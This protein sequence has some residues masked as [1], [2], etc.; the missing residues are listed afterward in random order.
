MKFFFK[1]GE[2]DTP[3]SKILKMRFSFLIGGVSY[4]RPPCN[5]LV[6]EISHAYHALIDVENPE[7]IENYE[8][9]KKS[10]IYENIKN[11][12]G[13][14]VPVSYG[15]QVS[16]IQKFL[17]FKDRNHNFSYKFLCFPLWL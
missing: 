9:V 5:N 8:R 12:F 17:N 3:N 4:R 10:K 1:N 15:L 11:M 7:I 2:R 13:D 16:S 6:H 14:I